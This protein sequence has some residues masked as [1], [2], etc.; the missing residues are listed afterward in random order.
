VDAT[1]YD[2]L[3]VKALARVFMRA[4]LEDLLREAQAPNAK[5]AS[6]I[7]RTTTSGTAATTN[8][9]ATIITNKEVVA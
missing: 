9:T 5:P 8:T 3:Q 2:P 1:A 7:A 4:A 6:H